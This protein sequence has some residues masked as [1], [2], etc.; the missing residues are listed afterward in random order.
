MSGVRKRILPVQDVVQPPEQ[1]ELH[2]PGY[3]HPAPSQPSAGRGQRAQAQD[4]HGLFD[5]FHIEFVNPHYCITTV[6]VASVSL[7]YPP[8]NLLISRICVRATFEGEKHHLYIF[9]LL[10]TFCY[11][12]RYSVLRTLNAPAILL[13]T[14]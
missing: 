12:C 7:R 5:K 2:V 3:D 14:T 4:D 6:S 8:S 9:I 1:P 13:L 11:D 10:Y